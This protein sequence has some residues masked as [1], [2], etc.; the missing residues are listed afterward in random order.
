MVSAAD[1]KFIINFS[2]SDLW[3]TEWCLSGVTDLITNSGGVGG[4][5][6]SILVVTSFTPFNY[7]LVLTDF[8][9]IACILD[10][11]IPVSMASF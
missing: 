7:W 11:F 10:M 3:A 6:F 4:Y 5:T 2:A 1:L 9:S 8:S